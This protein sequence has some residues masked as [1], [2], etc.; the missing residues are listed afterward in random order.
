MHSQEASQSLSTCEMPVK[1]VQIMLTLLDIPGADLS[2]PFDKC[3]P[4]ADLENFKGG[5]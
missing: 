5:F 4:G 2:E 3:N 1:E